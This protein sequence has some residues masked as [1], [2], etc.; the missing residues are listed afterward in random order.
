MAHLVHD[1]VFMVSRCL[2]LRLAAVGFTS[3]N[4]MQSHSATEIVIR[5]NDIHD[6]CNTLLKGLDQSYSVQCYR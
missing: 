3:T 1:E 5:F 6:L 2:Q 4:G